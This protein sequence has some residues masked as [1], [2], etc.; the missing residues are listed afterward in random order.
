M[1]NNP[2]P[3]DYVA[4]YYVLGQL[5]AAPIVGEEQD[6]FHRAVFG[7]EVDPK[8]RDMMV[9]VGLSEH[10]PMADYFVGVCKADSAEAVISSGL[11]PTGRFGPSA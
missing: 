4:L 8:G 2:E 10:D 11:C 9:P 3:T 5:V 7:E 1:S 6:Y